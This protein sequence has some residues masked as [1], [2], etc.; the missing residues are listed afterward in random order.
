LKPIDWSAGTE[1]GQRG[2]W[3]RGGCG[4]DQTGS[5]DEMTETPQPGA[6]VRR[7]RGS[8]NTPNQLFAL[9]VRS[10]VEE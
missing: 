8:V 10:A 9:T 4:N 5:D 3:P 6:N 1:V 2:R 7:S